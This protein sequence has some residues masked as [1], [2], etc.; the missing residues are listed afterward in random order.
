[1]PVQTEPFSHASLDIVPPV[2]PAGDFFADHET[3]PG[4]V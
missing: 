1:M 3:Y 4:M 2:G